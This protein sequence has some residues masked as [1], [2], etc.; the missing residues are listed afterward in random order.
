LRRSATS[1]SLTVVGNTGARQRKE[2][3]NISFD[4]SHKVGI[5]LYV[6]HSM[7]DTIYQYE[8]EIRRLKQENEELKSDNTS[9]NKRTF[10][11]WYQQYCD[12]KE[13]IEERIVDI[14]AAWDAGYK[15]GAKQ[16]GSA[17]EVKECI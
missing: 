7:V 6:L 14:R 11:E 13:L 16:F 10:E 8:R 5:E 15:I 12:S 4:P 2:N 1:I 3:M 17:K 9:H